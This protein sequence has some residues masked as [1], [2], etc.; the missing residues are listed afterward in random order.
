MFYRILA[1]LLALATAVLP[2]IALGEETLVHVI[3]LL[4][5]EVDSLT[6]AEFAIDNLPYDQCA[7]TESW[8]SDLIL[9]EIDWGFAIAFTEPQPGPNVY[10]GTLGFTALEDVGED[11]VLAVVQSQWSDELIITDEHF[12]V[13]HCYGG[14]HFFNCSDPDDCRCECGAGI[15][16]G[17]IGLWVDMEA[18]FCY[19]D[20]PV[21]DTGIEATNWGQLKSLY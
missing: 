7:I 16:T 13:W 9:G 3:V 21:G 5:H 2:G 11:Y 15:N 4:P 8:A 14:Y 12:N 20:L 17:C 10:L 1:I 18:T 19:Q 6:A